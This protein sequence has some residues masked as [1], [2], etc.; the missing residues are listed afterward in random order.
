MRSRRCYIKYVRI[1]PSIPQLVE[2]SM[3]KPLGPTVEFGAKI[4]KELFDEFRTHFPQYGATTWFINRSM[5]TFLR[6]VRSDE[7]YLELFNRSI[8]LMVQDS[9]K[10][11]SEECRK[12]GD[13]TCRGVNIGTDGLCE[14]CRQEMLLS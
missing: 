1:T 2:I 6:A 11:E 8:E 12:C 14:S 10:K 5:E 9:R 4:P 3:P 13:A 7:S